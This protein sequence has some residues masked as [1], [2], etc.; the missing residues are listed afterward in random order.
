MSWL[1]RLFGQDRNTHRPTPIETPPVTVIPGPA[2]PPVKGESLPGFHSSA[3]ERL[4]T[5]RGGG[6][7]RVRVKLRD[8][9]TPSQ[10][11]ADPDMFAGRQAMLA[12]LIRALEDQ[13]L[14]VV[15]FGDR[16][17][18]KTSILHVLAQQA[19]R[20]R[21][22]VHYASCGE[23]VDF[24]DM[25]RNVATAVPLLYHAAHSPVGGD[26]GASGTLADLLPPG[27][28]TPQAISD[29]FSHLTGT[30]L[31]IIID[32]FDRSPPGVFRRQIAELVKVLSD[33]S[34]RVQLLIAGVGSNLTELVEMIPSIRRNILGLAVPGMTE[35]EI[36]AL[37]R[38]GERVSGVVFDERVIRT[39]VSLAAGSPYIAGLLGQHAG[40]SA[41]NRGTADVSVEDVASAIAGAADEVRHRISEDSLYVLAKAIGDGHQTQLAQLAHAALRHGGRF[42]AGALTNPSLDA[43]A[44]ARFLAQVADAYRLIER[45]ESDPA[46]RYRFREE[47]V[48]MYLWMVEARDNL[49]RG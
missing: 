14:H 12:T 17:I 31:I 9:F 28:V 42:D 7:E 24:D 35:D 33:R 3:V 20:A 30:R 46:G 45:I 23:E 48:P 44:R 5:T 32:E 8:A 40:I 34:I 27:P 29:L 39:I 1:S 6:L 43:D 4:Q 22:L 47:S 26:A 25:F 15:L 18:G 2:K 11:V 13:K 38:N 19:V 49:T 41:V 16:G 36:A 21:Y 37:L 10:P